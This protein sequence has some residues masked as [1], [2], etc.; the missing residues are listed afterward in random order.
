MAQNH[1]AI[2]KAEERMK[3]TVSALENDYQSI[4]AGR[5][6][7]KL[8]DKIMV[9]YY[10]AMTPL[11]QVGN[12]SVPE[13]RMLTISLW[14]AS[15]MKAVEKAI[16]TSD[17]GLNPTNDGKVVRLVF[18]EPTVERRKELVKQAK[19]L[20]EDSKVA[21][22]NVRRDA[23]DQLRKAKKDSL[24]T[25]DELALYEKKCQDK[26][27]EYIKKIDDTYKAKEKDILEI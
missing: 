18:P 21:I 4:R 22:R 3:K 2:I 14:D 20:S 5:A 15:L 17:L 13:P 12:I 11:S 16:L 19:K 25:E 1:E 27:D 23:V 8:L 9:D 26:T 6:N 10:G 7:P 24:L